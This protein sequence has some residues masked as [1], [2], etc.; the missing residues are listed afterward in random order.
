MCK[1]KRGNER[2]SFVARDMHAG[3]VGVGGLGK[4]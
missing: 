4:C 2:V 3:E 1:G